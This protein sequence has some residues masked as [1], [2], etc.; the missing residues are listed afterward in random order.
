MEK[1]SLCKQRRKVYELLSYC[2]LNVPT[3]D[4]L[5]IMIEGQEI[6]KDIVED[7][8]K[9]DYTFE[10]SNLESYIQEYYDRFFVPKSSLF[11]PPYES[12]IRNRFEDG[13]KIKYG[14]LDSKETFHVKACYEMVSFRPQ[15]L[16]MFGP[17]KDMQFPDHIAFEVAFMTHLTSGEESFLEKGDEKEAFKWKSL[18]SQF[19]KEHLSKWIED[20]ATLSDGKE[21][22]LY[23]YWLQLCAAWIE[24]DSNFLAEELA[25]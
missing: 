24:A 18:Q 21:P 15:N 19:I 11:I 17:L 13:S 7:S 22:G 23:S 3:D 14:K 16:N 9:L 20:F 12:S 2:L 1:L 5:K 6:L 10:L 25:S 4:L 8:S